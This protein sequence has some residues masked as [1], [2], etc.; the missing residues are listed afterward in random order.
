MELINIV[1]RDE[2]VKMLKE[3]YGCKYVLNSSSS[4][5][6]E[7]FTALAKELQAKIMV[8]CVGGELTGTVLECMPHSSRLV[9]YGAMSEKG[10][11]NI[12]PLYLIGRKYEIQGFILNYWIQ[13]KGLWIVPILKKCQ[14]MM[15]NKTI[16]SKI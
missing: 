7:E 5:F 10:P 11:S 13:E 15:R 6:K 8:E 9:F 4:N 2:Q 12:D 3:E 1:R 16:E 14:K